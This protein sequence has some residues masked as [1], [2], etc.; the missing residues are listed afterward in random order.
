MER[1][2]K[3]NRFAF[4]SEFQGHLDEMFGT[5]YIVMYVSSS[6]MRVA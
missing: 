1:N 3:N 5:T 4:A 6:T 2:H